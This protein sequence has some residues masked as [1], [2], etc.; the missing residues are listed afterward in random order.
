MGKK[1]IE[2]LM[3]LARVEKKLSFLGG[4]KDRND[5]SIVG[6][7]V[8]EFY[9]ESGG[10]ISDEVRDRLVKRLKTDWNGIHACLISKG[11]FVMFMLSVDAI[12]DFEKN[13]QVYAKNLMNSK[14]RLLHDISR[15]AIHIEK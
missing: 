6:C 13:C 15:R 1:R 3:G 4:K 11:K 12:Q 9:E 7:A 10:L 14:I 8:R 5:R 2:T